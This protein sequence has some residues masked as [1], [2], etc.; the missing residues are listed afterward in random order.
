M[1]CNTM[2]SLYG[3]VQIS[4]TKVYGPMLLALRG[5]GVSNFQKRLYATLEWPLIP[6]DRVHDIYRAT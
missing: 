6:Y 2:G 5:G 1:L 4:V 3:S